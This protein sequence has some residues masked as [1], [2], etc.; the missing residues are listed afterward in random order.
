MSCQLCGGQSEAVPRM[1]T[2]GNEMEKRR[3]EKRGKQEK[4]EVTQDT[5]REVDGD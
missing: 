3:G 1:N 2:A 5:R 4:R